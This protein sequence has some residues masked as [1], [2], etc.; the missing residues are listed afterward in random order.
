MRRG[1]D[2]NA[3][4]HLQPLRLQ[5]ALDERAQRCGGRARGAGASAGRARGAGPR[6]G[7][8]VSDERDEEGGVGDEE[9]RHVRLTRR[10]DEEGVLSLVGQ[11]GEEGS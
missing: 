8:Q 4:T 9:L 6:R 5:A 11:D 1:E 3:G 7:E 10:A 2:T